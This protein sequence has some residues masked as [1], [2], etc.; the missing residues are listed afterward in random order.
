MVHQIPGSELA[1]RLDRE[2]RVAVVDTRPADSFDAWHLPG[3]VN[4]PHSPDDDLDDGTLDRVRAATDGADLVAVCAKGITSAAFALDLER[5]GFEDV[6]VL[7]GGMA[8]WSKVYDVVDVDVDDAVVRQIQRRATGCLGYVVGADG[9]AAVVDP[10]RQTEVF[11]V[12]T[13]QAG[14]TI[15]RVVDT[16]VHADHV[17]GGRQLAADL[18]VPYHLG[19]HA[20]DRVAFDF[21]PVA[22]GDTLQAGGVELEAI[23]APGHTSDMVNY[24]VGDNVLTADTLFV[25]AVGRTEL[26]FGDAERGA[27]RL[28]ETLHDRVLA[29]PDDTTILPGHVT[30]TP[31]GEFQPGRPG[32]PVA[33]RLGDLR[34]DLDLL[35]LDEDAFADRF[36]DAG[37]KP[38]NYE[39]IVAINSGR[40]PL[41]DDEHE[42][43]DLETG[44][45]N[46][47]A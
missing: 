21:E 32:E 35:A 11:E 22:D 43:T 15:E 5:H 28:H 18:G 1:D 41:P 31:D 9:E 45:N 10:T 16:H 27:R 47:A 8:G 4:V 40:E 46:C 26:E 20:R 12:A 34:D 7:A 17:S 6:G 44:P 14:L 13:Q 36:A 42:A 33:A 23:H 2:E 37:E 3:A 30:V 29:L 38:A 24:R 39:R 19:E 25:D